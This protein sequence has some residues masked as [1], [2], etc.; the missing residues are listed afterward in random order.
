M[1][2]LLDVSK[3]FISTHSDTETEGF[4]SMYCTIDHTSIEKAQSISP[5]IHWLQ[6]FT[7]NDMAYG[8]ANF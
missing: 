6:A 4:V 1:L 8:S 3:Y 5:I 2:V 7:T